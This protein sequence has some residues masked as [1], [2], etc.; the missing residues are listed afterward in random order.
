M[1]PGCDSP[2]A[3]WGIVDA[4]AQLLCC[5]FYRIDV[6]AIL[7]CGT[8]VYGHAMGGAQPV[9]ESARFSPLRVLS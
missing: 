5:I 1:G 3:G 9:C 8:G 7:H 6:T 2:C 4:V